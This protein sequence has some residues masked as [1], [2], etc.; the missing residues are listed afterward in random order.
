MNV[1]VL[2]HGVQAIAGEILCDWLKK[3]INHYVA[4]GKV[5]RILG[6]YKL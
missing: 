1:K 4:N 6:S 5:S 3:P 2:Q